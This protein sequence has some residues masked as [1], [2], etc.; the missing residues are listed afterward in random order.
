[1]S[2]ISPYKCSEDCGFKV[3]LS[4]GMPIWKKGTPEYAQFLPVGFEYRKCV[5]GYSDDYYCVECCSVVSITDKNSPLMD[6]SA[7]SK[8]LSRFLQSL[9]TRKEETMV[10]PKC[11]AKNS[12]L[13]EKCPNCKAGKIIS[14]PARVIR[15]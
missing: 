5:E 11:G 9:T 12:F 3:R 10:C 8:I 6:R 2:W 4:G 1:M 15:F 14:D 13:G 7:F